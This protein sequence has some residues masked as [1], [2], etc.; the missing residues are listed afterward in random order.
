L[1]GKVTNVYELKLFLNRFIFCI[2]TMLLFYAF[3]LLL[4]M[5]YLIMLITD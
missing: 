3:G 4:T 1:Q 2:I 5:F